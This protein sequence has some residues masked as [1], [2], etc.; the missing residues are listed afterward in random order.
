MPDDAY[1]L[2][3]RV[4]DNGVDNVFPLFIR[5]VDGVIKDVGNLNPQIIKSVIVR[6]SVL[7]MIPSSVTRLDR[8]LAFF[9]GERR[10]FVDGAPN[11]Q[12][13]LDPD[14]NILTTNMIERD[15]NDL[16]VLALKVW[17]APGLKQS[18]LFETDLSEKYYIKLMASLGS[19]QK[20]LEQ[21]GS[22]VELSGG[23]IFSDTALV[24]AK[25][26]ISYLPLYFLKDLNGLWKVYDP[27]KFNDVNRLLAQP[28]FVDKMEGGL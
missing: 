16:F 24:Y 17:G 14:A 2:G 4:S 1:I 8:Y 9:I 15:Y 6:Y 26:G 27:L 22:K 19:R 18:D 5:R 3:L 28:A 13:V 11:Y 7:N 25:V 21:Y 20:A 12:V 10:T 23:Y